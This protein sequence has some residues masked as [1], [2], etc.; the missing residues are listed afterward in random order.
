MSPDHSTAGSSAPSPRGQAGGLRGWPLI[1]AGGG[2]FLSGTILGAI[3]ALTVVL[4][5]QPAG[6]PALP[7]SPVFSLYGETGP[8]VAFASRSG[9]D[10]PTSVPV[11]LPT[12]STRPVGPKVG[13]EAPAFTLRDLN[14]VEHSLAA[15]RGRIVLL[16]FWASWCLPCR[17]EWPELV[18]F[19]G[20]Q[21]DRVV[22]LA[23]NSEEPLEVVRNFVG[24][25]L[26]P[27]PVL[28]DSD[29]RVGRAYRLSALPTTWLI[30]PDGIVRCV[31]PGNIG[32][33]GLENLLE[34]WQP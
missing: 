13:W 6:P 1:L 9:Q 24:P 34:R 20:R 17:A 16:H 23:V 3:L 7:T 4:Y 19:A 12:P 33:T 8:T 25:E 29:G 30:D 22:L 11:S 31:V 2:L 15:Y 18:A 28:V 32:A 21:D 27:F 10:D 14:G 5:R 26:P